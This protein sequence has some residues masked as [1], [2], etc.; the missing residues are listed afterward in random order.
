M[1]KIVLLPSWLKDG[2]K[3]LKNSF[4]KKPN[5]LVFD[6]GTESEISGDPYLLTFYDGSKPEY[7]RV[8]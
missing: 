3:P 4:P 5:L 1:N 7:L 8:E 6:T 2:V